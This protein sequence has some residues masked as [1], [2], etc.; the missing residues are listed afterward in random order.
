MYGA[1]VVERADVDDPADVL[2]LAAARRARLAQEPLDDL[3]RVR[4]PPS[5]SNLIATRWSSCEVRR[6]DD[7][8]HAAH[9]EHALDAVLPRDDGTHFE[10]A[11]SLSQGIATAVS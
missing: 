2:A 5:R 10:H 3:G 4:E 8:A 11:Q 7:D 6:G 9:A 1:P